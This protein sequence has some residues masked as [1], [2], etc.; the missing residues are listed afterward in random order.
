MKSLTLC[1]LFI[2]TVIGI[3]TTANAHCQIPCGIFGDSIKFEVLLQ[4]VATIEKSNNQINELAALEAP[5]AQDRQQIIRWVNNKETHA[6]FIIDE[7]ANYFLAQR[8]KMDAAHYSEKLA[9][10]HE[11]IVSAMKSK[12]TVDS[13]ATATLAEK[14]NVFKALYLQ[15]DH[16]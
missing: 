8:I 15:H 1:A 11:I 4:H 6:Q 9:L 16:E 12:Q 14:I 10:L 13:T 7:A 5:A 2:S 3:A